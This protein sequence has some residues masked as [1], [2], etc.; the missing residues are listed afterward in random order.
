M[1]GPMVKS[2][3]KRRRLV[4]VMIGLCALAV[5]LVLSLP[6]WL[7]WLLVPGLRLAGVEVGSYERLDYGRFALHET[8]FTNENLVFTAKRIETLQ[9]AVWATRLAGLSGGDRAGFGSERPERM[10]IQVEEWRLEL[11]PE[12]TK[13]DEPGISSTTEALDRARTAINQ[14]SRLRPGLDLRQ[15][16][17]HY[18]DEVLEVRRVVGG[19]DRI[20]MELNAER[21]EH[22]VM[23]E[24]GWAANK[25]LGTRFTL[26]AST[27]LFDE[28]IWSQTTL[29]QAPTQTG[30]SL[31]GSGTWSGNE[32]RYDGEFGQEAWWPRGLTLDATGWQIALTPWDIP[33][34]GTLEGG[35]RLSWANEALDFVMNW[36]A[37]PVE[38]SSKAG[39]AP[40]ATQYVYPPV[41]IEA[42]GQ[43][44]FEHVRLDRLAVKSPG[45]VAG[46]DQIIEV[47]LA[48]R[49]LI[50]P[51]TL[52][53][54][55]RLEE[56]GLPKEWVSGFARG[57][58]ADAETSPLQGSISGSLQVLPNPEDWPVGVLRV[59][60]EDLGLAGWEVR[61]VELEAELEWPAARLNMF[62]L[63]VGEG[64][65][66]AAA[67]Q[68]QILEKRLET[69]ALRLETSP[70]V[71]RP[72]VP[73]T[74][75]IERLVLGL[76]A[77]GQ[78]TPG[79]DQI[80][81][82]GRLDVMGL[83]L[84]SVQPIESV[85]I[86]W[87]P[88]SFGPGAGAE[89]HWQVALQAAGGS[90]AVDG[91]VRVAIDEGWMELPIQAFQWDPSTQSGDVALPAVKLHEPVTV[92]LREERVADDQGSEWNLKVP[93]TVVGVVGLRE[94]DNEGR[95]GEAE[96][97]PW[98]LLTAD[99]TWP[100]RGAIELALDQWQA[101]WLR[102]W[103]LLPDLDQNV[104]SLIW[105]AG[106]DRFR[107]KASWD[108]GPLEYD[109]EASVH[110]PHPLRLFEETT[111]VLRVA[112]RMAGNREGARLEDFRVEDNGG[113]WLEGKGAATVVVVPDDEERLIHWDA[114]EP[115]EFIGNL[116]RRERLSVSMP[117]FGQADL[118]GVSARI[119]A[120]GSILAP[121]G[122]VQV[123]F[124]RMTFRTATDSESGDLPP[125]TDLG[126]K[127]AWRPNEI[128]L[129]SFHLIAAGQS[130]ELEGLLPL[131]EGFW[132]GLPE[133]A[134]RVDV[135]RSQGRVKVG[136]IRL[137]AFR[138]LLPAQL[139]AQGEIDV[140]ARWGAGEE[141]GGVLT[142]HGLAMHP[143]PTTGSVQE[144][145]GRIELEGSEV[146]IQELGGVLGGRR[147]SVEGW[148]D[149][150][151]TFTAIAQHRPG[152]LAELL[153]LPLPLWDVVI[154]GDRVPVVRRPGMVIRT[155][156]DIQTTHD[157]TGTP[158]IAGTVTP[159]E[160]VFITDVR[161]MV[162]RGPA[163]PMPRPPFVRI[164]HPL[165]GDWRL[166]LE[167]QGNDFLRVRSPVFRG[168]VSVGMTVSG[169]LREP[170]LVGDVMIGDGQL[171]FPFG[172]LGVTQGLVSLSE[173]N[174]T[175]PTVLVNATSRVYGY[176]ITMN[177]TGTAESPAVVF[178]SNPPLASEAI[179]LMLTAGQ[180]PQDELTFSA[181]QRA[182]AL[183]SYL[184]KTLI[185][186]W[187]L[188][189]PGEQ[190]LIIRSGES[191][192]VGGRA[193]YH[194]EYLLADRWSIVGEYDEYDD[195]NAGIK[196]RLLYR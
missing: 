186:S 110:A 6:I 57:F 184:G 130:I 155:S 85:R 63:E 15:G 119:Q 61:R 37:M 168:V 60:S 129:E 83:T 100:R 158:L 76:N 3:R 62:E 44:S 150:E 138:A 111:E 163:T 196:Y 16:W 24:A 120:G 160:S 105:D 117:D 92:V 139:R 153:A 188:E 171:Q 48:T 149:L 109:M 65:A 21:L 53:F 7:P 64:T 190:R 10:P 156:L 43:V 152:S 89:H 28:A 176:Q 29:T 5:V 22:P 113:V 55:I 134:A 86:Q 95:S 127:L 162:P 54:T 148:M 106:L 133:T 104:Q 180:L 99:V 71:T 125:I 11:S 177:I 172:N 102:D 114:S 47:D 8:R 4:Q 87:V 115:I 1:S 179:L 17:I 182:T 41:L 40:D 159:S 45:L 77:E 14:I 13:T 42:S 81:T 157:G 49:T 170:V 74:M 88:A 39:E 178:S 124:E 191:I 94:E 195:M 151:R 164:D 165:V 103:L 70:D 98:L 33:G 132:E 80:L 181:Q 67:G 169:Q 36:Q 59:S 194:L 166:K 141:V 26:M 58:L 23:V 38:D 73:E 108:E 84:P 31:E 107:L 97:S 79:L 66:L 137:E 82:S 183:A 144:I 34:Y 30:W 20:E 192:S 27:T 193:T 91:A 174:P 112:A 146:R 12:R 72:F 121:T 167:V 68:A 175:T 142:F 96:D 32:W 187:A 90:I 128:E 52:A 189:E 116:E 161:T 140:E 143:L 123:D 75:G 126:L 56:L 50:R 2:R 78:I 154:R 35:V 173:M 25:Q 118:S 93:V 18:Q 46:L 136:P 101:R 147:V 122:E 51:G 9:P 145:Q 131:A 69:F 19:L 185:D 135:A